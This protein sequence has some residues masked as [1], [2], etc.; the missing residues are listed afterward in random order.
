MHIHDTALPEVKRIA[1]DIFRDE[2]G[3][4]CERYHAGK[5]AALGI[6]ETFVQTNHSRSAPGV[7]RGLHFQHA[8]AQ[9]KLV[10]VTG[11]AILDIAVD[12]RPHSPRFGQ[13]V[14]AE[15][16]EENAEVLWIPP[17][18]AHGFC[19]LGD[20]PA[21][22]VYNVTATYHAAGESG[23]RFDDA[24]LAI[25]WPIKNPIISARDEALPSLRAAA[26][27]LATWF[28]EPA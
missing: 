16:S 24:Q 17:G 21:D 14:A 15:L 2:R 11:G 27:D 3:F 1:L 7:I 18:F 23:I 13:Y 9:G 28:G 8:P 25:A 22:V 5:F 4:F 10:G 20:R 6:T 12:I 19:V 26:H